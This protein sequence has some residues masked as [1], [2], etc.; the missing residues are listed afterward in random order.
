MGIKS[1]YRTAFFH[2][3]RRKSPSAA[4]KAFLLLKYMR[5]NTR[6]TFFL[7]KR[8]QQ[9]EKRNGDY[10]EKCGEQRGFDGG[11]AVAVEH[12]GERERKRSR[13]HCRDYIRG[14]CHRAVKPGEK[15]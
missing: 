2:K 7:H 5:K 1:G 15:P 6:I 3:C 4:G 8:A 12:F 13:R 9:H 11:F 10:A 14:D